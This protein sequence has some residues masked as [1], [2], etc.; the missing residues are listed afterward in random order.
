M[1]QRALRSRPNQPA[2]AMAPPVPPPATSPAVASV[3]R[4]QQSSS[5]FRPVTVTCGAVIARLPQF[6]QTKLMP[7]SV[8]YSGLR[9]LPTPRVS[10]DL[11]RKPSCAQVHKPVAHLPAT[12]SLLRLGRRLP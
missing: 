1:R 4:A 10:R 6:V 5:S 7:A 8:P 3:S 11:G 9:R 2:V 12:E